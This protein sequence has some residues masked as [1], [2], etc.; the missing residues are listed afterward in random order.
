MNHP[1]N[2]KRKEV[3]DSVK[4]LPTNG[5]V[6]LN[7]QNGSLYLNLND[8]WIFNA[9]SVLHDY[10][11]IRPPFFVY[12]PFPVGAHIEIVNGREAEDYE[13]FGEKGIE[14]SHLIGK[15]VDFKV[16][17]AHMSYPRI[18]KYGIEARYKIRVKSP[19]LSRIRKELTGLSTGPNNGHFVILV[20][21]RNPDL[22]EEFEKK[23][24]PDEQYE[25]LDDEDEEEE[26]EMKLS[27]E[28]KHG[29]QD[30]DDDDDY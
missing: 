20:G 4:D 2:P 6:A 11:Y 12:P 23:F 19:E 28:E 24:S 14:V 8:D 1:K 5:T 29:E 21:L 18:K 17:T 10:G 16:V 25:E 30:D 27:P 3:L 22:N 9:L 15:T 7:H 26:F 13:L